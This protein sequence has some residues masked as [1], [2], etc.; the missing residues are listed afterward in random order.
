[1]RREPND[2]HYVIDPSK[3]WQLAWWANEL[4]TSENALA[5]AIHRV[6]VEAEAVADFLAPRSAGARQWRRRHQ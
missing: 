6:G 5:E 2:K 1:M 4:D 3:P